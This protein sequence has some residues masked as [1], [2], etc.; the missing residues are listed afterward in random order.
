MSPI[1]EYYKGKGTEVMGHMIKKY[2]KKKGVSIFYATANKN[3]MGLK[4]KLLGMKQAGK[5]S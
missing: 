4:D 2:G 1:S 3:K 5:I